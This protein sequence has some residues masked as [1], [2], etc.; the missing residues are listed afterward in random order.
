MNEWTGTHSHQHTSTQS[1]QGNSDIHTSVGFLCPAEFESRENR[2][3]HAVK[4][5][6]TR[7]NNKQINKQKT[8]YI[9]IHLFALCR[10]KNRNFSLSPPSALKIKMSLYLIFKKKKKKAV[11]TIK[12]GGNVAV[13]RRGEKLKTEKHICIADVPSWQHSA[14]YHAR[15]ALPLG[16]PAPAACTSHAGLTVAANHARVR[17]KSPCSWQQEDRCTRSQQICI[18]TTTCSIRIYTGTSYLFDQNDK[19][20]IC[21]SEVKL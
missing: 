13:L 3:L 9:Y 17:C 14:T 21:L 2:A 11:K 8:T 16:V 1:E 12:R 18:H 15:T 10:L 5:L 4:D 6:H 19:Q 20:T 7:K